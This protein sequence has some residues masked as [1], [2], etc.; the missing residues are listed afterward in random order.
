MQRGKPVTGD[1]EDL[2]AMHDCTRSPG[3]G[4]H[5]RWIQRWIATIPGIW[6]DT[7]ENW[8]TEVGKGSK[9]I[10]TSHTD[11][12][13]GSRKT[14]LS[15]R[16]GVLRNTGG[17]LGADDTAGCWIMRRM[18][19]AGVPGLYVFH[20]SEEK[21]GLGSRTWVDDN[22][23]WLSS[24]ERCISFDRKGYDDV[25]TYQSSGECCSEAFALALSS[26]LNAL[27]TAFLYNPCD[28]GTFT[29][30]ANYTST[31]S[32]C[33]NLSVGYF[34]QHTGNES[35]DMYFCHQLMTACC[36]LDWESLPAKRDKTVVVSKY[37]GVGGYDR[38]GWDDWVNYSR[39]SALKEKE[40]EYRKTEIDW[41]LSDVYD[42]KSFEDILAMIKKDPDLF[43]ATLAH[44]VGNPCVKVV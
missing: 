13:G 31:V 9:T 21:G 30:S 40:N 15:V 4:I 38:W 43:A 32:E 5:E 39:G 24:Y 23:D 2:F 42:A 28:G 26:K 22:D 19:L 27:D 11:T 44:L 36:K 29:D 35:L 14:A 6:K 3:T 41:V 7:N 8:Y 20:D 37:A 18:I 16:N 25:I 17:V 1:L 34:N 33:T 10:F 12:V